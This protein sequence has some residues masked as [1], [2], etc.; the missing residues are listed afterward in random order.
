[1]IDIPTEHAWK[2]M[3]AA[4]AKTERTRA[5]GFTLMEILLAVF[6]FGIVM[7]TLFGSFNAIFGNVSDLSEKTAGLEMVKTCL[8]RMGEDLTGMYVTHYP[9]Y[10]PSEEKEPDLH[11][12]FGEM[13]NAGRGS[14]AFLTFTTSA[15]LPFHHSPRKG[16]ARVIYY[17]QATPEG[18]YLLK[19]S[20]NLYPYP[21]VEDDAFA[22]NTTDPVLCTDVLSFSLIYLDETATPH[23]S[24]DSESEEFDH[25]TPRAI[26][27]KLVTGTPDQPQ[28]A[29]TT[30]FLPAFREKKEPA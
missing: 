12:V 29:G 1:M 26:R 11:R 21:S 3:M 5:K 27:I 2:I 7:T 18:G 22:Q 17:V 23:E 25:A 10:V 9:L 19:R 14:F 4:D 6:I 20:D 15:H 8:D 16:I 24:W 30:V 13:R 28:T